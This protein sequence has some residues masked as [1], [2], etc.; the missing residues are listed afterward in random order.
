MVSEANNGVL[1]I[2]NENIK[3]TCIEEILSPKLFDKYIEISNPVSYQFDPPLADTLPTMQRIKYE[4]QPAE[5]SRRTILVEESWTISSDS[6]N[7]VINIPFG[8]FRIDI[9]ILKLQPVTLEIKG[10]WIERR[11]IPAFFLSKF[12][13]RTKK[14]IETILNSEEYSKNDTNIC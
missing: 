4:L 9:S 10:S 6:L 1:L 3:C 11:W 5:L 13:E 7:G 8:V 12:L 2:I 14:N